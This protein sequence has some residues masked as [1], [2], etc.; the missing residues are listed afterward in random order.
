MLSV[1]RLMVN[2]RLLVVK[3]W[4]VKI[5]CRFFFTVLGSVPLNP[6]LCKD[7]LYN[8]CWK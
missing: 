2:S 5:I 7:Q 3:F 4:G 6:V 8:K 1:I